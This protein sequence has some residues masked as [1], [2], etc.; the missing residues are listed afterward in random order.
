MKP[1]CIRGFAALLLLAGLACVLAVGLFVE[2]RRLE[3]VS[4]AVALRGWPAG[5][6]PAR[7][8][9]LA[10]LHPNDREG[11]WID[12]VVRVSLSLHPE[13]VILLGDYHNALN[14][15]YGM[16]DAEL[17]RR[18]APL[19]QAC[20][21]YYVCGNHDDSVQGASIRKAFNA[22]GFTDI[23]EQTV[24]L[25]FANG[26]K[27]ALRGSAYDEEPLPPGRLWERFSP[28]KKPADMP[29]AAAAHSPFRFMVW[30]LQADLVVSGHTHGGQICLPGG[31]PL[32]SRTPW[33]RKMMRGG[34]HVAAC[35]CPLYVTRGIGMSV[36]PLRLFCRPEITLLSLRG[37][38]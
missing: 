27:L 15:H 13:A 33:T 23:E 30:G 12:H 22:V 32:V 38:G 14:A 2:P 19:A 36:L 6:A 26:C 3:V 10:D 17:A 21:V 4:E 8:L 34:W 16:P 11:N 7:L 25:S 1:G 35:G 31:L 20:P 37:K 5:C 18:L 9:L 28:E 29:L 24:T